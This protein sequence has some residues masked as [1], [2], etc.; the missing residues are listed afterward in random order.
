MS[1]P[2]RLSPERAARPPRVGLS[3]LV[4]AMA[5]MALLM[6][7]GT[8]AFALVIGESP[9][10]ALYR[11]INTVT[12]TGEVRIPSSPAAKAVTVVVVASGVVLFLYTVGVTL[13]LVV[14][15]VVSGA[16]TRRRMDARIARMRGHHII[17]GY[18]RVGTR[19]A[20][21]LRRAGL[22]FV[23]VDAN[24]TA[25]GRARDEGVAFVD[26]DGARDEVLEAAGIERAAG[27]VACVDD[28]AVN[29]YI[30]LTAKGVR[31]D[32]RVVARASDASAAGKL[33]RAGADRVISPYQIAG[34]R[35]AGLL[36]HPQVTDFLTMVASREG[37]EFDME[38]LTVPEDSPVDGRTLAEL[39]LRDRTGALLLAVRRPGERLHGHPDGET[40]LKAGDTVIAVGTAEELSALD[41]L[42][43]ADGG[44]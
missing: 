41:R 38:E 27:L 43:G 19:V 28:D 13:E 25:V 6:A 36:T 10:D 32:L 2:E 22:E 16:W 23:V 7:A 5:G 34:E 12:T 15:G 3:H 44:D 29:T 33:E 24:P 14:G 4:R 42:L 8:L 35:M 26:G 37:W 20:D 31:P 1:E 21:Q 11:T 18:G 39:D 17:C 30:V 9:L 40:R